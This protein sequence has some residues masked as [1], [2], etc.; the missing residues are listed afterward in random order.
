ML[1][2]NSKQNIKKEIEFME[3]NMKNFQ[4]FLF[5]NI[6]FKFDKK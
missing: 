6:L 1:Y 4:N 2:I 5:E 3:P